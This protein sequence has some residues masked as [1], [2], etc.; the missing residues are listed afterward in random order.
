M[1]RH[2]NTLF[3]SVMSR[4]LQAL[5]S[6]VMSWIIDSEHVDLRIAVTETSILSG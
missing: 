1:A 5:N 3:L 4:C 2:A 6:L